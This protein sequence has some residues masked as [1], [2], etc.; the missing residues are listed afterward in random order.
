MLYASGIPNGVK[1]QMAEDVR[2]WLWTFA[3][4]TR[5]WLGPLAAAYVAAWAYVPGD[6]AAAAAAIP[7]CEQAARHAHGFS[8]G[9]RGWALQPLIWT[10]FDA[11]NLDAARDVGEESVKLFHEAGLPFGESRMELNVARIAMR[12][13]ELDE[14]WKRAATAVELARS[15]D[16]GFVILV[17]LQFLADVASARGDADIARD[18]L[19]QALDVAETEAPDQLASIREKVS[20]LTN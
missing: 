10:N 6:A 2:G 18:L 4:S 1:P 8:A 11:G 3:S 9:L 15:T 5:P 17:G 19:L 12:K 7:A 13:G 20:S 14:A 16:D